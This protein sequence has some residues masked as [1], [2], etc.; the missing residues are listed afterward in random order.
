M[1]IL[2]I[3]DDLSLCEA[4][5]FQL[6]KEQITVDLCH[7]GEEAFLW[8]EQ[9]AHDM[10]LLDRMLPKVN[11]IDILHKIRKKGYTTPVILI[12]ALGE[13][14]DKILGL[15]SGADDYIVK[16]FAFE[17]LM[18][19]IRSIT[20]RPRLWEDEKSIT[21]GDLSF[22]TSKNVLSHA[23]GTSC[24]LSKREGALLNAFIQNKNQVLTRELLLSRVWGG[25][26]EVEDG[27]LDNYIHFLRRRF[28]SFQST[29]Q[30]K[31]VR[32]V[33]YRLEVTDV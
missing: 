24:S 17:E 29:V 1:K 19:R 8:I 22:D 16:P 7:D 11:G 2:L 5:R 30:L 26:G 10:I 4:L 23:S 15:D 20:R 13:L 14:N 25:D 28:K 12:T 27:N 3:E 32:G 6:E 18:A 9:Q 31:T 21:F 33:G